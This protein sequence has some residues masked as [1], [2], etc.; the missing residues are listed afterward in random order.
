MLAIAG[1]AV[2]VGAGLVV[3]WRWF[4]RAG[5]RW[6]NETMNPWLVRRGWVGA[7]RSELGTLEHIGRRSGARHLTPIHPVPTADGFRIVV[8]LADKSEWAKNVLAAGHCRM[9]LHDV[10]YELDEPTM[11]QP[12]E[13]PDLQRPVKWAE[14]RLGFTYLRLHTFAQHRG[15]LEPL[16]EVTEPAGPAVPES[17]AS[18]SP[19][20][21]A[22]TV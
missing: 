4:P 8:P 2:A 18:W 5:V 7:G 21:T 14:E 12:S 20:A 13:V 17:S 16:S 22:A 11:V 6:A 9:Q 1:F 10:V 19:E 3:Y 15:Q